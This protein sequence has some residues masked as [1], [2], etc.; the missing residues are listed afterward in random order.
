MVSFKTTGLVAAAALSTFVQADYDIDP[1]SVP[2]AT[3][4]K[5]RHVSLRIRLLN[6]NRD[7]LER[8]CRDEK[9]TCPLICQ[10]TEPRTTLINDCDPRINTDLE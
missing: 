4:G 9:L 6:T 5:F 3:R 1:T 10:Q 8:W 7:C 2:I